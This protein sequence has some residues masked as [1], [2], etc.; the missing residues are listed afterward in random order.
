MST[1]L[2]LADIGKETDDESLAAIMLNGLTAHYDLLV[3][4]LE[5]SNIQITTDLV[6]A[7]L[8]NEEPK[9]SDSEEAA[10]FTK[11]SKI[12]GQVK[13]KSKQAKKIVCYECNEPG[14]K[15]LDCPR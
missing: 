9:R 3:M 2:Q 6:K 10:L 1:G 15:C 12:S 5:N 14:H 11:G 8:I 13:S 4:T 7:K